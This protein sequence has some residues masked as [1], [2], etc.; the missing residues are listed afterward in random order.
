MAKI[1]PP[2][3]RRIGKSLIIG[4]FFA[5]A[6]LALMLYASAGLRL[7]SCEVC[8][9]FNGQ[10][11]CRKADGKT[12]HE[13]QRTATE[14]ACAVLASGMAESINCSNATPKSVKCDGSY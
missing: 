5:A 7:H 14:T 6:V 1:E 10:T 3:K 13:A 2:P 8:Q 12:K 4:G 9:S 11:V